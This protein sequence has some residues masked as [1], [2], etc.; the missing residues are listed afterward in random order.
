MSDVAVVWG[1]ADGGVYG[2]T[3]L[4]GEIT[5]YQQPAAETTV[6][7]VYATDQRVLWLQEAGSAL[8][9]WMSYGGDTTNLGLKAEDFPG[10]FLRLDV[11]ADEVAAY[12]TDIYVEKYTF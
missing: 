6:E 10:E 9:L 8:Q 5:A 1:E 2:Y 7:S 3:T 4:G 11:L 12:W